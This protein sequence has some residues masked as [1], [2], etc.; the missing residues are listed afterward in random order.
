MRDAIVAFT[1][2]LKVGEG[3]EPGVFLGPVQNSMQY[4]RVK[5]FFSEIETQKQK[6]AVGGKVDETA[7]G[8]FIQPTVIDK[9]EDDSRLV[10]EEPFGMYFDPSQFITNSSRPYCPSPLLE[11]RGRSDCPCKRHQDGTRCFCLVE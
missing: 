1:R 3:N 2:T 9:P 4:E 7:K 10:L 5:G 6:V 11:N 8:Y